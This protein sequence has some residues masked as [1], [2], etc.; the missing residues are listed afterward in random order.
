M[1]ALFRD[2]AR[3]REV[4]VTPEG[5]GLYRVSVDGA[6]SRLQAEAL[7]GGRLRLVSDAGVSTA[8][9]TSAGT[10]R[11]VRLGNLD[12]VL[13]REAGGRR[14]GAA[15]GGGL[16]APMPG[17][18]TKVLVAEGEAVRKGQP[19]VAIEAMKMEH[20]VRAP[21]DGRV[22]RVLAQVGAMVAGGAPLVTLD[23]EEE[24]A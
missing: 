5:G 23:G 9:V 21:R 18:V 13:E 24:P 12:F 3:V 6:E 7:E 8:E 22:A 4:E 19:L 17:V 1:R 20:A 11:F 16:E 15:H 14:R 2:G 10:R